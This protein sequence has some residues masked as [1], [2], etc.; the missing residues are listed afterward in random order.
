MMHLTFLDNLGARQGDSCLSQWE[1]I[2][3]L[4][5]FGRVENLFA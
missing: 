3:K 2:G 1:K 5:Y 4:L